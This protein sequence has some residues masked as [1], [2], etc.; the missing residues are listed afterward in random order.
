MGKVEDWETRFE[1][2]LEDARAARQKGLDGRARVC[3]RRALGVVI[4]EYLQRRGLQ[5]AGTSAYDRLKVLLLQPD[6]PM[7]VAEVAEHFLLRV[8][9]AHQLPLE[10]DLIAEASWLREQL[11]DRTGNG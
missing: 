8:T 3:A 1:K 11:L 10:A 6:L 9:P 5:V 2:E 7:E 4:G